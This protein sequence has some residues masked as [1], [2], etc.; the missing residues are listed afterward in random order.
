[1]GIRVTISFLCR[2]SNPYFSA[3]QPLVRPYVDSTTPPP[4]A[5]E[6]WEY[7]KN[8]FVNYVISTGARGSV[9]GWGTTLQAGR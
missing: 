6:K 9:V 5:N 4:S 7:T 1:M 8:E 3:V 2:E